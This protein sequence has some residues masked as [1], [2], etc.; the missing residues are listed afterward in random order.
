MS[1]LIHIVPDTDP[2]NPREDCD[3]LLGNMVCWHSRYELGDEQP[4]DSPREWALQVACK[5]NP[6]IE[7]Q[8]ERFADRLWDRLDSTEP[9]LEKRL[10]EHSQQVIQ[11]QQEK[12]DAILDRY[13]IMV[14]LYLYDHSGVTMSTRPFSCPW[15]SGQVGWIYVTREDARRAFGWK[16]LSPRREAR[17]RSILEAEVATY[18]QYLQGEV[19]GYVVYENGVE[20]D[21]CW[22]FFSDAFGEDYR[23]NGMADHWPDGWENAQIV[24]SMD[25]HDQLEVA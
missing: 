3:N 20:V 17:I 14:P 2:F 13:M 9:R 6:S 11:F 1:M 7:D 4:A 18:D 23:Q 22:G 15:D 12:V 10:H 5:F 16:R 24:V 8:V 21:S 25:P 19:Y